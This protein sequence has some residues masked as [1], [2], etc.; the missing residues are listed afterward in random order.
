MALGTAAW[1]GIVAGEDAAAPVTGLGLVGAALTGFAV[2]WPLLLGPALAAL[3]SAYVALLLI[4]EPPLDTR[5]AGVAAALVVVGEL[6]GW[7][8]EL[9]GAT[10]DEPGN[11]WRRPAWIAGAGM[12]ALGLAWALLAVADLAR[13]QGLAIEAVG[14]VAALAAL[15]VVRRGLAPPAAEQASEQGSGTRQGA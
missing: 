14:A 9:A 8:G 10:R 4:D 6:V 2:L 1:L 3:A 11:A 12:G 5:A 7:A 15:L 13:V